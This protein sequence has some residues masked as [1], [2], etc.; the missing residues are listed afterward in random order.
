MNALRVVG[1]LAREALA[2]VALAA[3]DCLFDDRNPPAPVAEPLADAEAARECW[4]PGELGALVPLV[5]DIRNLVAQLVDDKPVC[6]N[7]DG[8]RC[9]S[10]VCREYHDECPECCSAEPCCGTCQAITRDR[11]RREA[12]DAETADGLARAAE[13]ESRI[14]VMAAVIEKHAVWSVNPIRDGYLCG[15]RTGCGLGFADLDAWAVHVAELVDAALT[16]APATA[17]PSRGGGELNK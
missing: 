1:F 10:C 9:M 16:D 13:S 4:E 3:A 17:D 5:E 6:E 8:R 11:E 12:W 2:A 15:T 14:A 7:C